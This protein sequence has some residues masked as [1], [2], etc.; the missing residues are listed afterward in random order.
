[1]KPPPRRAP[2]L[3]AAWQVGV[4][5]P[6]QLLPALDQLKRVV[7]A[8]AN[9]EAFAR[10][11]CDVVFGEGGRHAVPGAG[12]SA[13]VPGGRGKFSPRDVPRVLR[14]WIQDLDVAARLQ[15]FVVVV[16]RG[17]SPSQLPCLCL[18]L[19]LALMSCGH[20]NGW[21]DVVLWSPLWEL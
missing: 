11:V 18:F 6:G 8:T 15:E 5:R 3:P 9:L 17:P 20:N 2:P 14:G 21:T 4:D 19:P 7:R 16:A 1:M 10:E 12:G 13:A